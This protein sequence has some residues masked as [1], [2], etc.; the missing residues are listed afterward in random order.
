VVREVRGKHRESVET[1]H[2]T[3]PPVVFEGVVQ[4]P[5]PELCQKRLQL[6]PTVVAQVDGLMYTCLGV[7]LER[8]VL[9][10]N[11]AESRCPDWGSPPP[12]LPLS[13]FDGFYSAPFRVMPQVV[14]AVASHHGRGAFMVPVW[15]NG[16]K[17]RWAMANIGRVQGKKKR[18]GG[19]PWYDFLMEHS[20]LSF[21]VGSDSF[22]GGGPGYGVSIVV[23]DFNFFGRFKPN[24]KKIPKSKRFTVSPLPLPQFQHVR[25]VG[26]IP[27][28]VARASE[29]S[30][31]WKA[32]EDT[33]AGTETFLSDYGQ[34]LDPPVA[35]N[36][37]RVPVVDEWA[38]DFP[39]PVIAKIAKDS[40]RG[41]L[42][43]RFAGKT[44]K[45]VDADN[46]RK[47]HGKEAE[48][49][50]H[51][52]KEVAA[53]RMWGPLPA[54]PFPNARVCKLSTTPKHKWDDK[55]DE[56][57][58][59]S[60]F[61]NNGSSSVNDLC[62]SPEMVAFHMRQTHIRDELAM[63]GVGT[64]MFAVDIPK[65]FRK[66]PNP[67]ELLHLFV[68]KL[69]HDDGEV[70]FFVDLYNPFGWR[71]SE[72]AWHSI[73]EIYLWKMHAT[74]AGCP[75]AFVDNFFYFGR[76]GRMSCRERGK[77][78]V[79]LGRKAGMDFHEF[80]E[81][82][83]MKALG[84]L[85]R[86]SPELEMECGQV[87][88]EAVRRLLLEFNE[89]RPR[90]CVMTLSEVRT[91]VGIMYFLSSG[92]TVGS[93]HVAAFIGLR[94]EGD[95][96]AARLNLRPS[97]VAITVKDAALEALVFWSEFFPSW[98]RICPIV[99]GFSPVASYDYVGMVDASTDF[100]CGG[101]VFNVATGALHGFVHKWTE[102]E[103]AAAL[104]IEKESTGVYEAKGAAEW[105]RLFGHMC[106]KS[107]L[108]LLMDNASA[109]IG[110][111]R[112]YS[113]KEGLLVPIRE[114]RGVCAEFYITL[115]VRH[116]LTSLN[117][118]ADAL[119]HDDVPQAQCEARRI[120][121][122]EMMMLSSPGN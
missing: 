103:R 53:G 122:T 93:P 81:G 61:S 119:S 102:V 17:P 1:L 89:R 54:C 11:D 7:R 60:D 23:A 63:G 52:D 59:V 75:L 13:G 28:V 51:F 15:K 37:W 73:Q 84:W 56:F 116:V 82:T 77:M 3:A 115:R 49:R 34:D 46:S 79:E 106:S 43:P 99:A 27:L 40:V 36:G 4:L 120:F 101:V 96:R 47:T 39:D 107:R 12:Y 33:V 91:M 42:D 83:E 109:V 9:A 5:L 67:R 94:T 108:L 58:L 121:G 78:L 8:D 113:K 41:E 50:K 76:R 32:P 20:V 74:P 105:F 71:P 87:K 30:R 57:R 64:Q 86:S 118:V 70:E 21:D 22:V 100:G 92:F 16:R 14:A 38:S 111:D 66:Q 29:V 114:A 2:D 117:P 6:N 24:A 69:V 26:L 45:A 65:C 110:V 68:Y 104:V 97:Q 90:P 98:N 19:K 72:Y 35:S 31:E 95:S 85:W 88:F 25:K 10:C 62:W 18:H 48:L 80:Q 44:G 112:A 55:N